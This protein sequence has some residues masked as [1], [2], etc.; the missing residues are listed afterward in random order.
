MAGVHPET[1]SKKIQF[2]EIFWNL[3]FLVVDS[4]REEAH[5]AGRER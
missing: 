5:E 1:K 4:L 2:A 3:M